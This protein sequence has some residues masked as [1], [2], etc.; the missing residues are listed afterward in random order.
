MQVLGAIAAGS[1]YIMKTY[2]NTYDN[3]ELEVLSNLKLIGT[4]KEDEKINVKTLSME[5]SNV[6][7]ALK[8][9]FFR[10]GRDSTRKFLNTTI[11]RSFG[12]IDS[13]IYNKK[14][15]TNIIIDLIR[16]INGLRNQ[17]T[18]YSDDRDF[19]SKIDTLIQTIEE[20]LDGYH[21]KSKEL[22]KNLPDDCVEIIS[23]LNIDINGLYE[24]EEEI[25]ENL[26]EL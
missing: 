22:F 19:C 15:S 5:K 12:I 17:K 1:S 7:T 24:K 21:Q 13:K 26:E 10:E 11:D 16:S 23:S 3:S 25:K 8:R 6:F 20:R 14:F 9:W 4:I 2:G 18:T